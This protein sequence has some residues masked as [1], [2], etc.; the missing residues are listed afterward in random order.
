MYEMY[1]Q[2]EMELLPEFESSFYRNT[3][4]ERELGY[5][6]PGLPK[7]KHYTTVK[8]LNSSGKLVPAGISEMNASNMNPGFFDSANNLVA[9]PGLQKALAALVTSKYKNYA[10]GTGPSANDRFSIALVDLSGNKINAPQYA[11]WGSTVARYVAST[12][13]MAVLYGVIQLRF[14]LENYFKANGVTNTA[15]VSKWL[16]NFQKEYKLP[17]HQLSWS[18]LFIYENY[19]SGAI[20]VKTGVDLFTTLI[21]AFEKNDNGAAS[22][23]L[24]SI[25][26]P[27]LA[28]ALMQ[29]GITHPVNGGLWLINDYGGY[30]MPWANR[31]SVKFNIGGSH[32]ATALSC[33]TYFT[34]MAQGRLIN[35]ASS[36]AISNILNKACSFFWTENAR[37]AIDVT[38]D[39][40]TKC[41]IWSKY[42]SDVILINYRSGRYKYVAAVLSDLAADATFKLDEM[43]KDFDILIR[44][45]NP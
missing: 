16:G 9:N 1:Q 34:L 2:Q 6:V 25:S 40:P 26:Y 28:S 24:H 37:A 10:K 33:A 39:I 3:E 14:D 13:K 5:I 32:N 30:N 36:T 17:G 20:K 11:G 4:I 44:A 18:K 12:A 38:G 22:K 21:N 42:K 45:N 19:S 27:Y 15:D 35:D 8:Q 29:S 43:L 23:L 7:I 41:G 31:P